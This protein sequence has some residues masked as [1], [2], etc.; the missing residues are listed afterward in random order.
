VRTAAI[1]IV[2]DEV[3]SGEVADANAPF[4]LARLATLGARVVR[5]AAVRDVPAEVVDEVR[6]MRGIAD[7]VLVAGGIG[8][9]HDD[10]TRPAVAAA[11]GVPLE[12]LPAAVA[13]IRRWY[14][15]ATTEAE[16][17]MADL[18]RG[19]RL[20]HGAK[21]SA[22]GFVASGVYVFPGVPFLLRDLVEGSTGEFTGE[23]LHRAEVTTELREGEIAESLTAIQAAALDAAI[24]SYPA[25][26]AEGVWRTR[27]VVRSVERARAEAVAAD[28]LEAF[29]RITAGK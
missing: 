13:H 26:D 27:I 25:M 6:R 16:L 20:L 5:A 24:G 11:L 12:R 7:V 23:P 17:S 2:G 22:L 10:V 3:L 29:A 18:P 1:L 14:G 28:V 4:L 9:T 19:S 15:D 21:T 8:P